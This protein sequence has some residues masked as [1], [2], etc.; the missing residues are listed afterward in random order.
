MLT[1][2]VEVAI[3][4]A[5]LY[6]FFSQVVSSGFEFIASM[7]NTR[8]RYLRCWLNKAL[9]SGHDKNWAELFYRH[10]SVDM[11]AKSAARPPAYV[12]SSV[13]AKAIVDLVIDEVRTHRFVSVNG[14]DGQPSGDM[15]YEVTAPVD[16]ASPAVP[17]TP[18][19][20]LRL[21]LAQ[22]TAGDFKALLTT[23]LLNAEGCSRTG[24]TAACDAAVFDQFVHGLAVW[25]DNYMD[26]VSGWYKKYIRG[27]LF[28]L[29]L[30]V[31]VGCNLDSLHIA[32][33]LWHHGDE[34]RRIVAAA[35]TYLREHPA[36]PGE[37][38]GLR[39]DLRQAATAADTARAYWRAY[40]GRL[41]SLTT[42]LQGQGFP[43]GWQLAASATDSSRL[44]RVFLVAVPAQQVALP[45]PTLPRPAP[46]TAGAP[47][48]PLATPLVAPAKAT[49]RVV[50]W[51]QPAHYRRYQRSQQTTMRDGL[52]LSRTVWLRSVLPAEAVQKDA[53]LQPLIQPAG[54]GLCRQIGRTLA[55]VTPRHVVGWLLTALALTFGAPFWFELLNRFV[56][57]RNIGL[58]PPTAQT[59]DPS[60]TEPR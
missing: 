23:I 10:P 58:K 44:P 57:M 46:A 8:G 34:R 49:R 16:P 42:A 3:S 48:T 55:L 4:L 30:L 53:L 26:R 35:E 12:P 27:Y 9:N 5:L 19:Q 38:P 28:L 60:A 41:D 21:G 18:L 47:A 54:P 39:P 36:G 51:T 14:P 7:R 24:T 1:P 25:Y 37:A 6:L 45:A 43:I 13:F 22:V 11:L 50:L 31:A 17:L 52:P 29:G 33:Y 40:S 2:V 32:H 15:A 20:Q 59:T 56:N